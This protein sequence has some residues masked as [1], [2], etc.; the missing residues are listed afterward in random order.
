VDENPKFP[1]QA[2]VRERR[3]MYIQ[4]YH[5]AMTFCPERGYSFA[6]IL[7]L[8]SH[9]KPIASSRTFSFVHLLSVIH[10]NANLTM[11]TSLEDLQSCAETC[12]AVNKAVLED[13]IQS[14]CKMLLYRRR[15][16]QHQHKQLSE[17]F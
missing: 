13:H 7:L 17:S 11:A 5:E 3:N 10:S 14:I 4:L 1:S 8:L 16:R 12:D 9:Y 15:F 6:K 2:S